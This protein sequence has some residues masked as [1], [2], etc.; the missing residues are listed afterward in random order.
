MRILPFLAAASLAAGSLGAV[1][2]CHQS[3][4]AAAAQTPDKAHALAFASGN[5]GLS[6]PAGFK[7]VVV[8]SNLGQARHIVIAANGDIYIGL[9]GS[10]KGGGIVALRDV[11]GDGVADQIS[12]F[13]KG[14]GNGIGIHNGYLYWASDTSVVRF[15]M[16]KGS[17]LPD[18]N[19]ETVVTGLPIQHEHEA[20][21]ITFD[22]AGNMYVN[23]GAPSNSCQADDRTKGSP[24][25][26]P[27]P[28]LEQHGGIWQ[29]RADKLWQTQKDGR[30]YATGLRN[31]VAITWNN[32]VN[33]LYA[34]MHGRDQLGDL[35]P[36]Y[37][38]DSMSAELPAE[39]FFQISENGN[40]G[41]PYSYY[42]EFKKRIMVSPEYGGDGKKEVPAGKYKDP[43]M[44]FPGHWA[45]DG[46]M[47]YSGTQFPAA[48]RN[49]AFIAF[50]GS[51]NRAPLPQK[52]YKVVFVPFNGSRPTGNYTVFADGFAGSTDLKSPGDA[53]H[54]PVGL[55]QG[56]DGSLYITD[57]AGGTLY[58]IV[59]TG[60]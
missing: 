54:R 31:C 39:T 18:Q 43:I 53:K 5:A 45:P 52:G 22:D 58:R 7:A 38:T 37:F 57:D 10:R 21:S 1:S 9:N 49:G 25:M 30:R 33:S 8:A 2:G 29:F 16:I 24:G 32:H 48:Y 14:H 51:W 13:G 40:Y 26:S 56:T 28:I 47:F 35:F 17:L 27:C 34:M 41:W 11:N 60:S 46:L 4:S 15:R 44:A 3:S 12:Y 6:L 20:K 23:I 42:D 36:Q 19:P 55:A 59:Y 50:H